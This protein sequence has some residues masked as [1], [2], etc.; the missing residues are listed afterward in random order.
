MG[1]DCLNVGCVPSKALIRAGRWVHEARGAAA[2]GLK[3]APELMRMYWDG[4]STEM[5][6]SQM[7]REEYKDGK[8]LATPLWLYMYGGLEE[9]YGSAGKWDPYMKRDFESYFDDAAVADPVGKQLRS[10]V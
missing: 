4:Y 8:F 6:M 7:A 10:A 3:S 1:G 5:M 9:L 2:L